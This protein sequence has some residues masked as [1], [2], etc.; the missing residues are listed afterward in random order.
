MGA[1]DSWSRGVTLSSRSDASDSVFHRFDGTL[2]ARKVTEQHA[3]RML[4][5]QRMHFSVCQIVRFCQVYVCL[6]SLS[7]RLSVFALLSFEVR[8][9]SCHLFAGRVH[10]Q[11]PRGWAVAAGT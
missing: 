9:V 6:S 3:T 7:V 1:F 10:S 2:H 11:V 5:G 8:N 4:A